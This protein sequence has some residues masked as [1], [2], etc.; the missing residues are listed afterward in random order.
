MRR[1]FV[2]SLA[3]L[4]CTAACTN[5]T[6]G[7][8][9]EEVLD[10]RVEVPEA[11]PIEEGI[12]FVQPDTIIP[13]GEER[14]TCWVPEWVPE[15]DYFVTTFEAEQGVGGHHAVALR[16]A[17]PRE[18]GDV[19]DCTNI[20]S[21][22]GFR[23]L[24][25]PDPEDGAL[26]PDGFHVRLRAGSDVV[27]QSHYINYTDKPMKVADVVR[28]H[29][30]PNPEEET[31]AGYLIMNHGNFS[32]EARSP[33][34]VQMGCTPPFD[35][36]VN[37]LVLFGHM[38]EMGTD[39]EVT[40]TRDG[41]EETIYEIE[42]WVEDFRDLPPVTR[43]APGEAEIQ[44]GDEL[45][46]NCSFMNPLDQRVNFPREMCTAVSYYYPALPGDDAVITCEE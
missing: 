32:I 8:S 25:L 45:S 22:A 26:L 19:F 4:A 1:M 7:G 35:E 43:Y 2:A 5:D 17:V 38:H 40:R 21:L 9:S 23:P 33:G 27:I 42:H 29:W 20:E 24:I 13:P 37:M 28:L 12:Q 30:S 34:N 18:P 31:E 44:P 39:I 6:T 36:S 15:R 16:S 46:L 11:P 14:M 3:V 10:Y 41:E